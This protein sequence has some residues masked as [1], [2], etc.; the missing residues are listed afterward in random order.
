MIYVPNSIFNTSIIENISRLTF[1]VLR[2]EMK[3][4]NK[5]GDFLEKLS[6]VTELLRQQILELDIV[7][8]IEYN[9]RVFTSHLNDYFIDLKF[10]I[11]LIPSNQANFETNSNIVINLIYK[12]MNNEG[13][14]IISPIPDINIQSNSSKIN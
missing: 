14:E 5:S 6:N 2:Y 13:F 3:I 7:P 11:S 8:K 9:P 12:I 10:I 4:K 1:R